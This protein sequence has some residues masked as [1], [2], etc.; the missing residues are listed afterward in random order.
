MKSIEKFKGNPESTVKDE[1]LA[2]IRHLGY[3]RVTVARQSDWALLDLAVAN[4][5]PGHYSPY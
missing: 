1:N 3:P 4:S 2:C 5:A